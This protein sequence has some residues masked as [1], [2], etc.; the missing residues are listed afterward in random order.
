MKV[1]KNILTIVG[2]LLYT[3]LVAGD[4]L[5]LQKARAFQ[6]KNSMN[7]KLSN[8]PLRKIKIGFPC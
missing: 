6:I 4:Y 3:S 7:K 2:L 5:L 1:N 8:N